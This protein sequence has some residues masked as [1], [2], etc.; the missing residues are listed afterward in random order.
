MTAALGTLSAAVQAALAAALAIAG[1]ALAWRARSAVRQLAGVAMLGGAVWI[2][3]LTYLPADI[4]TNRS[5]GEM[6]VLAWLESL[7]YVLS[8]AF[9]YP[10]LI[11]LVLL[12]AWVAVAAGG[13]LREALERRRDPERSV[14]PWRAALERAAAQAAS[15]RA[16]ADVALDE[17]LGEAERGYVRSLDRVRF[18]VRVGPSLGL[19]GTLIPMATALASLAGGDLPSLARNMVTAFATTVVGLAVGIVAYLLSLERQRWSTRDLDVLR[20]AAERL[21]RETLTRSEEEGSDA[22]RT[23]EFA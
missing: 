12:V 4:T 11:G 8:T 5:D 22:V 2:I 14:R 16:L 19:M 1:V 7:I 10:V 18:A 15:D 21:H 23:P 17:V 9:F 13:V 3:A 20:I 6:N